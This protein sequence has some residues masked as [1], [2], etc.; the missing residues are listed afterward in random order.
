M[1]KVRDTVRVIERGRVLIQCNKVSVNPGGNCDCNV[2]TGWIAMV[3]I[4]L[5]HIQLTVFAHGDKQKNQIIVTYL[6]KDEEVEE[7]HAE[8]VDNECF[9]ELEGLSVLHVFGSQPEE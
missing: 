4:K 1:D 7:D 5:P 8:I 2:L 6:F 3:G 9:A